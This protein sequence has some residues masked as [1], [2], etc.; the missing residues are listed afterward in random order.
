[1]PEAPVPHAA[2]G[3]DFEGTWRLYRAS[4]RH[5]WVPA[6]LLAL[7]WAAL[8]GW[9]AN[10]LAAADDL[11]ALVTQAQ[12]L[13]SAPPFWRVVI[14]ACCASTLLFCMLIA[15]IH[16]VAVGAPISL[17][18]ACARALRSFPAA[19]AAAAVYMALTTLGTLL[20][21]VPGALL[22]GMWQL[23][24][25][26]M[27]AERTGPTLSFARSWTLMRHAWWSA[28]TLTAVV[29]VAAVS[30]P[31]ACNA[32][33]MTLAVLAGAAAVPA[34]QVALLALGTS[35]ALTAP[36]LPAALVAVY[37]AQLHRRP[38]GV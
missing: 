5:A 31:L 38:P 30:I 4:L 6:A 24:P 7:L 20:F 15:I 1:M 10:R 32:M 12:A 23:W 35:A 14:A 11:F 2:V 25:V 19:L 3:G 37:L 34:Q 33:A 8:L 27:I 16:A 29:T 22:W 13:V 28:T 18:G 17:H 21:F 9:L 36:L 26:V